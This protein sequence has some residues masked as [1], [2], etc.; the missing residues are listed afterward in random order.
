ML[1]VADAMCCE[2]VSPCQ[3][4][5]LVQPVAFRLQLW[6]Q[7][8]SPLNFKPRRRPSVSWLVN[9]G[10]ECRHCVLPAEST[11]MTPVSGRQR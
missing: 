8:E 9:L 2:F 5:L 11:N 7:L 6:A 3:R 10:I 4:G 1:Q